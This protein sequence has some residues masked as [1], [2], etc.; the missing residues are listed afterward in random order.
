MGMIFNHGALGLTDGSIDWGS[1]TI[2]AR[3]SRTSENAIDQDATVM[4]SIGLSA[5]DV[6]LGSKTGPSKDNTTDRIEYACGNISFT[7][8]AAGAEV[9]KI[10]VFKFVTND[11]DSIPIAVVDLNPARTPNG[12][13]INLTIHADGLFYLQQ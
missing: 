8:V 5:T 3:L 13:D 10:V 2:R 9:D 1:D 6:A 4:T 7:A 11:G 12:G